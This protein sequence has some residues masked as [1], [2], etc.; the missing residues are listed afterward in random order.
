MDVFEQ[1]KKLY[2]DPHFGPEKR[3]L[4]AKMF[5][6]V[7]T[8]LTP[9][10]V[11]GAKEHSCQYFKIHQPEPHEN[12]QTS[13]EVYI[14]YRNGVHYETFLENECAC[15]VEIIAL[16]KEFPA[17]SWT[18]SPGEKQQPKKLATAAA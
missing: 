12:Y 2:S 14:I 3:G 8:A 15:Q 16:K 18:F 1:Q 4:M 7:R 6:S 5:E 9:D 17:D 11:L 13:G 10:V